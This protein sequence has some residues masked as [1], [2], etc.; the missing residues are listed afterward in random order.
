M[1]ILFATCVPNATAAENKA[2]T[3]SD[4]TDTTMPLKVVLKTDAVIGSIYIL[5]SA[6]LEND[7]QTAGRGRNS[8]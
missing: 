7:C 3:I 1:P 4:A 5:M 8:W 2:A 6:N